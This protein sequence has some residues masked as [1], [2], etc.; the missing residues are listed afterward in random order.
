MEISKWIN[1]Q[2]YKMIK[3]ENKIDNPIII[4]MVMYSVYKLL[5]L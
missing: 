4:N 3:N 5:I 1:L 2:K